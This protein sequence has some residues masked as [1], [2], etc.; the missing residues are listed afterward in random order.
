[1]HH[2]SF[3]WGV[4]LAVTACSQGP[5]G[6]T[7]P[8]GASPPGYFDVLAY[9]AKADVPALDSTASF[10]SALDAAQRAGGGMVWMPQGRFWFSGNLSI[11]P[12]VAVTTA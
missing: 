9:G 1:M 4:V 11:G 12:N 10:Q 3:L 8:S 2:G 6:P 7:G 5:I